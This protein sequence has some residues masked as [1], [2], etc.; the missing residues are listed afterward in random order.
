[1]IS[2]VNFFELDVNISEIQ[3]IE[4][5][6]IIYL[7]SNTGGGYILDILTRARNGLAIIIDIDQGNS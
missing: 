3:G 2:V 1:M 6:F 7:I 5:E 4:D